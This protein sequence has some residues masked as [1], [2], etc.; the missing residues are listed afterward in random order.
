MTKQEYEE[1]V[2]F[3][4]DYPYS[5]P[6]AFPEG[7]N[8]RLPMSLFKG[9]LRT[10]QVQSDA[11]TKIKYEID[12]LKDKEV[13]TLEDAQTALMAIQQLLVPYETS[14]DDTPS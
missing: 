5:T 13:L 2:Q 10:I 6:D 1:I 4:K 3:V 8:K 7:K 14:S 11:L 9:L 12:S